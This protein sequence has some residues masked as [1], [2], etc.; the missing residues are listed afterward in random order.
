MAIKFRDYIFPIWGV[1]FKYSTELEK[2]KYI[3]KNK[4]Y[5]ETL[6]ELKKE[7]GI[8]VP[9]YLNQPISRVCKY[10]LLFREF[11]KYNFFYLVEDLSLLQK[12]IKQN[13]GRLR[14]LFV[15]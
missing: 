6:E 12:R 15:F 11:S 9:D 10:P 4:K 13:I 3:I 1:Y 5:Q 7:N 8:S 14:N 2:L